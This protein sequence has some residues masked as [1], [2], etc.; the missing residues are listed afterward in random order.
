M[1]DDSRRADREHR[2]G[3]AS[4][5]GQ[6]P[7]PLRQSQ[8]R[9]RPRV[10]QPSL[11]APLDPQEGKQKEIGLRASLLR[12][13]IQGLGVAIALAPKHRFTMFNRYSFGGALFRF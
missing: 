11:T 1:P 12:G 8:Q 6:E 3:L 10:P 13:R 4:H 5:R 7:Q 9:V 2:R